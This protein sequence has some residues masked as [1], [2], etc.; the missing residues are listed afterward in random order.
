MAIRSIVVGDINDANMTTTIVTLDEEQE[1]YEIR[2]VIK[3]SAGF[4]KGAEYAL[5]TFVRQLNNAVRRAKDLNVEGIAVSSAG[6]L[7]H[8]TGRVISANRLMVGWPGIELKREI[9]QCCGLPCAV[10]GEVDASVLGEA[11]WGGSRGKSECLVVNVG[12]EIVGASLRGGQ[13]Q[14]G[15]ALVEQLGKQRLAHGG[16]LEDVASVPAILDCYGDLGGD[17]MYH[18]DKRRPKG[19]PMT[20]AEMARRASEEGDELSIEAQQR[21]GRALGEL[22]A[23]LDLGF[24]SVVLTGPA[25]GFGQPYTDAVAE[26]LGGAISLS[27]AELGDRAQLIGAAEHFIHPAYA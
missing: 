23:S 27:L 24:E 18:H 26:G 16:S 11:R 21:G 14:S 15:E 4:N 25:C 7:D 10:I 12:T 19:Y 3:V 22:I 1:R 20:V 2:E 17:R 5:P 9:E 13:I 8:E 6:V